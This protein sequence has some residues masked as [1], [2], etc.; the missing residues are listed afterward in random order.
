VTRARVV[1]VAFIGLAAFLGACGGAGPAVSDDA[2]ARLGAQVTAVRAA[3]AAHDAEAA[4]EALATF[5]RTVGRLRRSGDVSVPR[6]AA[7]LAAASDVEAQLTTITTTT[8]TTTTTP[9]TTTPTTRPAPPTDD[10]RGKGNG[11]GK[12]HGEG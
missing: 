7:L 2:S 4:A 9:T 8:T 6:A 3:V 10:H 5:R 12:G 1:A 11:K